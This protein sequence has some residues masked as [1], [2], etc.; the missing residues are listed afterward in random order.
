V[1]VRTLKNEMM[2]EMKRRR[3]ENVKK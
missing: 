2:V 1:Q 3:N